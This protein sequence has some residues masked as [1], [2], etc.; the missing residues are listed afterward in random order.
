MPLYKSL[1]TYL[2]PSGILIILSW[3]LLP[4]YAAIANSIN[5]AFIALVCIVMSR[6]TTITRIQDFLKQRIIEQQKEELIAANN[7]LY[8]ISYI[9]SLTGI[10]NRR[11]FNELM[12]REWCRAVRDKSDLSLLM[13]DIDYFK[14][15]ND[16]FGHQAGMMS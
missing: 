13:I 15:Y 11:Y 10:P 7:Q 5:I 4:N 3:Y 12:D 6:M 1:L 8:A 16:I 2:I 14:D 9:D